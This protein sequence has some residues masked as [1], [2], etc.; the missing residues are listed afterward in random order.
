MKVSETVDDS[1]NDASR[2][3]LLEELKQKM[4]DK[5]FRMLLTLRAKKNVPYTISVQ[6]IAFLEQFTT[7]FDEVTSALHSTA[8][9]IVNVDR[10]SPALETI[11]DSLEKS[12]D[13]FDDFK[14]EYK[15]Q[16]LY[17]KYP[18]FVAV[19]IGKRVENSRRS[20]VQ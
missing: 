10:I 3:T 9:P 16:K 1:T 20:Q 8:A 18:M 12:K 17:A 19:L 11:I 4:T 6:M 14:T 15:I 7:I 13:A 5:I 2:P